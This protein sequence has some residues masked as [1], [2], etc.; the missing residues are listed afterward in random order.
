MIYCLMTGAT[1]CLTFCHAWFA[2]ILLWFAVLW[3]KV[4]YVLLTSVQDLHPFFC[5]L[6]SYVLLCGTC[7]HSTVT[8]SLMTVVLCSTVQDLHPFYCDLL[9]LLYDRDHYKLSLG[10]LNTARHLI[11]KLVLSFA[12]VSSCVCVCKALSM[13]VYERETLSMCV[14]DWLWACVCVCVTERACACIRMVMCV[15]VR[16][17]R[18]R[19]RAHMCESI[20]CAGTR[21]AER[22]CVCA[23][24]SMCAFVL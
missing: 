13:C 21:S 9:S 14:W 12:F 6:L 16:L 24:V 1:S 8:C 11:D 18:E 4:S 3:Q 23:W 22:V 17:G 15:Y 20:M 7:I 10:Q 19:E 2:S 5:N